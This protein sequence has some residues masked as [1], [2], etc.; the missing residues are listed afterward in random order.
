MSKHG[1]LSKEIP[2]WYITLQTAVLSQLPCPGEISEGIADGWHGN[3]EALKKTLYGA[4]CPPETATTTK[5]GFN[6]WKTIKLGNYKD[7]IALKEAIEKSDLLVSHQ[8]AVIMAQPAFILADQEATVDLVNVS[9][10]EL[11]LIKATPLRDIY[12]WAIKLGLSLCPAEVGPQLWLQYHD[13]PGGEWL[14]IAM[15]AITNSCGRPGIFHVDH[16]DGGRWLSAGWGRP[17]DTW[18]PDYRFVFVLRK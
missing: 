12:A 18:G 1:I 8:A 6:I 16:G 2:G 15:E 9:V 3:R 10:A 7:H 14:R 5:P 11:G 13:Q 17:D 4:L